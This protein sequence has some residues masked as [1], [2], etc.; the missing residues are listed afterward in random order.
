MRLANQSPS[1]ARTISSILSLKDYI[2]YAITGCLATDITHAAYTSLFNIGRRTWDDALLRAAGVQ[3]KMLPD[4]VLWPT[5]LVGQ[6]SAGFRELTGTPAGLPVF[7][8]GPDGSMGVIG[9]GIARGRSMYN[10]AGTSDVVF[11]RMGVTPRQA[12]RQL[13]V[14]PVISALEWFV[15]GPTGITGGFLSWFL[16]LAGMGVTPSSYAMVEQEIAAAPPAPTG[17]IVIPTLSGDR[18]PRWNKNQKG[19]MFGLTLHHTRGQLFRAIFEGSAYQLFEVLQ[20]L[21]RVTSCDER[22]V[23]GGGA[24]TSTWAQVRADV[25]GLPIYM[26]PTEDASALGAAMA[27]HI[28]VERYTGFAQASEHMVPLARI[29]ASPDPRTHDKYLAQYERFEHLK[30]TVT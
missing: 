26:I 3:R 11:T 17:I 14:N 27:A 12:S 1:T 23:C 18:T 2:V 24:L 22:L 7:C 30:D 29:I 16:E 4:R 9:L 5:D 13:V 28:G 15:G 8:G 10:I 25:L 21:L 19:A 20:V 6:S